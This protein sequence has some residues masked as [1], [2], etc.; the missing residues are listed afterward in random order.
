MQKK[1]I[2][3]AKQRNI[4]PA[5]LHDGEITAIRCMLSFL[6]PFAEFTDELQGD[7]VTSSLVIIAVL[8]AVTCNCLKFCSTTMLGF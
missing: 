7:G 6:E 3:A 8:N 1:S 4:V 2:V 5:P